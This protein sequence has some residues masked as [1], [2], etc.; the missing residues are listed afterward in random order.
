MFVALPGD[1]P[2][3]PRDDFADRPRRRGYDEGDRGGLVESA[4]AQV[5]GPGTALAVTAWLTIVLGVLGIAIGAAGMAG[6]VPPRN[7]DPNQPV[8]SVIQGL[9]I[10][11]W[12][13]MVLFGVNQMKDL[14]SR[15]WGI[16]AAVMSIIPC[17]SCCILGI[18]FGIWA[19]IVLNRSDVID[20]YRAAARGSG[21]FD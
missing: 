18:P 15:G 5:A 17:C 12:N 9:M 3:R 21:D 19:L 10:V 14:R 4:R 2:A 6:A 11:G 13:A 20:G 8:E 7:R 1:P 16:A